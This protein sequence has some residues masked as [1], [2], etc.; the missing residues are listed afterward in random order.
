[1]FRTPPVGR[2][3]GLL[4]LTHTLSLTLTLTLTLSLSLR[5]FYFRFYFCIFLQIILYDAAEVFEVLDDMDEVG[6]IVEF[7]IS[8][9]V[10]GKCMAIDFDFSVVVPTY[11][12]SPNFARWVKR[13]W[14]WVVRLSRGWCIQRLHRQRREGCLLRWYFLWIGL[15]TWS[16]FLFVCRGSFCL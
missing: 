10:A 12:F 14:V 16:I 3:R 1:M 2:L 7:K 5:L 4:S 8:L 15:V 13:A 6:A 9:S 11:I